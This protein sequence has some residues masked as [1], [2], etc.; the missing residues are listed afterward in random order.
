MPRQTSASRVGMTPW[1]VSATVVGLSLIMASVSLLRAQTCTINSNGK[2]QSC[3]ASPTPTTFSVTVGKVTRLTLSA[4]SLTLINN[5]AN[6]ADYENGF[7]L[8]GSLTATGFA[9]AAASVTISAATTNFTAPAGATKAAS[10]LQQSL[11]G[12]TTWN[13]LTTG[14]ATILT[15][16][17]TGSA[18]TP[19]TVSFRTLLGW[20]TDPPGSYSLTINFTITAP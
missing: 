2:G 17:P 11:D 19:K 8:A 12:G 5:D 9:N 3:T 10:T 1:K 6:S 18:G 4:T 15:I 16:P 14:G 7:K 20:A 13:G